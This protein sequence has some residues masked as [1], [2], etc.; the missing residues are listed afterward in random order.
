MR[1]RVVVAIVLG[2]CA[3]AWGTPITVSLAPSSNCIEL[4]PPSDPLVLTIQILNPDQLAVKSWSFDLAYNPGAFNPLNNIGAVPIE[5]FEVG[6]YIPNVA[7]NYNRYYERNL[8]APDIARVG[9]LNFAGTSGST[10]T[11]VLGKLAI[12]VIGL[13]PGAS[14][15]LSGQIILNSGLAASEVNF[16]SAMVTVELPE[17][18][19]LLF[20][21]VGGFGLSHRRT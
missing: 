14:F 21:L 15:S 19:C 11:G 4:T 16:E 2:M 12:D 7:G 18:G 20:V 6:S 8:V 9:V 5:G 1:L 13:N 10:T 3:S 17:P